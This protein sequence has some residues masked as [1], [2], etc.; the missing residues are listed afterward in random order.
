MCWID[1]RIVDNANPLGHS[2]FPHSVELLFD[3]NPPRAYMYQPQCP[4][5]VLC[6]L[7]YHQNVA[8]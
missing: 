3:R 1:Y 4:S 5:S 8:R 6:I 2:L 7:C